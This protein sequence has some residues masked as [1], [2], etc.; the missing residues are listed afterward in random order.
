MPPKLGKLERIELRDAW[1]TEDRDFTPWLAEE[2]N[3]AVLAQT[4]GM[5]L[6]LEAQEQNVGPFRADILCRDTDSGSWVLI[7]NQLERTDHVHLGQLMTYAAGLNAVTIVWVASK[8][9]DEHRAALDW[10]NDITDE[11]FRFFGLEVELWRIGSSLAAPKYN[12]MSQPN[13]WSRS[14]SR[15]AS[16]IAQ[17]PLTETRSLQLE[18]WTDFNDLLR[19][20][21]SPIRAKMPQAQQW[22][23]FSVGRTGFA[24]GGSLHSRDKWARVEI[25][26][27]GGEPEVFFEL[28]EQKKEAIEIELGYELEWMSLP[29]RQ[30]CR[31]VYTLKDI[32]PLNRETHPQVC[33]WMKENLEKFNA[34][35]RPLIRDLDATEY[36]SVD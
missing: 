14:I 22:M 10:L 16:Q 20:T 33:K 34:V 25:Y 31:I 6:E 26:I 19:Q 9:T 7:E 1:P 11:K 27:S 28:L 12:I 18:F 13:D 32:D 15:A 2:E 36:Q 4:L 24:L 30:G 8:F 35:F 21:N 17:G 3:L 5:E 29:E 23:H